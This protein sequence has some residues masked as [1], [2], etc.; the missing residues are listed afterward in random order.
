[1]NSKKSI[2]WVNTIFLVSTPIIALVLSILHF[3]ISGFM[4]GILLTGLILTVFCGMSITVGYH[5][6]YSHKSFEASLPVKLFVLIFGAAAFQNSLLKWGSDH[7]IHHKYCDQEKD[8]YD[9][10]RGFFWAH[11]GW[12][13][14]KEPAKF[15]DEFPMSKDLLNDPL[16]MWQHKYYLPIAVLAGVV[17]PG[18]VGFFLGSSLGGFAVAGVA[19]IVLVHH[20]TFFI[21]SLCHC[22]GKTTY[23]DSHT[24]KDSPIMA[25]LTFGEGYH[26]FHH[27]FQADYRNGIKW[28]HFDPTKWA[29][30]SLATV[31]MAGKLKRVPAHVISSA[32]R[33]MELRDSDSISKKKYA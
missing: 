5:R 10:N 21:N 16:V 23:S 25:L 2:D 3:K 13:M 19:R 29:I 20:S 30:W 15:K 9:I 4:P 31:G 27:T 8:P 18:V 12:I 32:T 22:V 7:R 14:V 11:M 1:M 6:L 26:N 24:A 28:Y 17:L 33:S